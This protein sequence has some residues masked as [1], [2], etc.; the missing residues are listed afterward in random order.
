MAISLQA[1]HLVRRYG[2]VLALADGNLTVQ[3]GEVVALLGANGSGKSTLSKIVTG[4]VSPNGG[5]LVINKQAMQFPNPQAARQIGIAAVYQELSLIPDM[6]VAENIGLCHE[7]LRGLSISRR[8]LNSQAATLLDLFKGAIPA[9]L[10][11]DAL[12][13]DL[14]PSE[15]QIVEILKAIAQQP[16]LIIF[17]EATA[18]LDGQ[19][20]ARLFDLIRAWKA[21]G[22]AIVFVSH[23]MDEIFAI[24]DRA[25]ILR[26]GRTVHNT[27]IAETT[28]REV[29][30]HM[31]G[32]AISPVNAGETSPPAKSFSTQN[33]PSLHASLSGGAGS[34]GMEAPI[35]LQ[36]D[37]LTTPTLKAINFTLH[38]GELLGLGG[39]QGQGQS[40]LLLALFGAV[41]FTGQVTLNG[42][43]VHFTHPRQAI[44]HD[45]AFVPGDRGSEG[46]LLIRSIL[47]NLH[48][49]SW[50]RF[51]LPLQMSRARAEADQVGRELNLVMASLDAPVNSLS[52]GNAQ[53]VVIGK[54]L[55]RHPKLLLLDD[56]T[57][58]I[59]VGAKAEFYRLLDALRKTDAAILFYS[60][61]DEELLSLCDRIL[62]LHDGYLSA[63]LSGASLDRAQLVEASINRTAV[64]AV[65]EITH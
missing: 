5:Q 17:D 37:Q 14:S 13:L 31:I 39:L 29:L 51:G 38:R 44:D 34:E 53:K 59:D 40:D 12:V 27:P 58:G 1:D 61:D 7:P 15:R 60:S 21:R 56:P 23:R 65:Y 19:Q 42:S 18:S 45:V 4:V 32:E 25:V 63:E 55:L 62:V 10:Q 64:A 43:L 6:T 36:V 11:P 3:S 33:M 57:K 47:E 16:R 20:V 54:W 46:L 35:A 50:S 9:G 48:L 41:P 2:G 24:A 49:P 26:N 8:L 22:T 30:H 28:R 52:G